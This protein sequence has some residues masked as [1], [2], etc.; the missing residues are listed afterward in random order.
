MSDD[1]QLG[2]KQRGRE[3][4]WSR[5]DISWPSSHMEPPKNN[6]VGLA[7]MGNYEEGKDRLGSVLL[8][9][10]SANGLNEYRGP[11]H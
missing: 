10:L 11:A 8:G 9:P 4:R 7:A 6:F 2:P 1:S 3:A 5:A